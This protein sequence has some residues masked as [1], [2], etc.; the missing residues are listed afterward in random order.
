MRS[1]EVSHEQ[2]GKWVQPIPALT[3]K[4]TM[5]MPF[6]KILV[7]YDGSESAK[8]AVGKAREIAQLNSI[9]TIDVVYVIPLPLINDIE[10]ES[11][12]EII[13]M[14]VDEGKDTLAEALEVLDDV[15]GQA[16]TYL[17][18]GLSPA[19]EILKMVE[20]GDYDLTIVGSRGLSGM[21]QYLG[22]VSY[23]ILHSTD[24]PVLVV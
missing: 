3:M 8:K 22:S 23:K 13:D 10:S 7:A 2:K 18:K 9:V 11:L 24:M 20:K 16:K 5:T 19:A 15:S 12:N 6:S 14:M 17:L 4:G 21:R 1:C